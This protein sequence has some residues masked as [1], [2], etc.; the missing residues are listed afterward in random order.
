MKPLPRRTLLVVGIATIAV[1]VVFKAAPA[2]L[3]RIREARWQFADRLRLLEQGRRELALED[4][5]ADSARAIKEA[6]VNLAPRLLSGRTTAEAGDALNG[7]ITLAADRSNAKLTAV[8]AEEDS[9][10]AGLLRRVAVRAQFD[11]DIRGLDGFLRF[12]ME[13][14]NVLVADRLQVVAA[15]PGVGGAGPEVLRVELTIRGW[16]Q[17]AAP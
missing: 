17:A 2:A 13:E 4:A 15:E 11:S 10:S 1:W 9:A 14:E 5:I 8:A 7:L 6:M 16:Y 12:I 3:A